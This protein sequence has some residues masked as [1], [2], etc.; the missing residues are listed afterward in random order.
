M[1]APLPSLAPS[2][3]LPSV[4]P[5][6]GSS[7]NS[8]G[9]LGFIAPSSAKTKGS[10]QHSFFKSLGTN[11]R[12]CGTCHQPSQ[13]M[14]ISVDEINN[15]FRRSGAS[16]PLFAPVDGANC[17]N[18]VPP[19]ETAP[20]RY[21]GGRQGR[22]SDSAKARSLLLKDGLIRVFMPLN[23]NADFSIE[24]D[25][26]PYTC[27]TDPNFAKDPSTGVPIFSMYR[28]PLISANLAFKTEFLSFGA[29][30]L[31]N[32]IMWDGR[33]PTLESQAI[34]ATFGHAQRDLATQGNIP[35][36]DV[37]AIVD[38]ETEFFTAQNDD[39]R[40]GGLHRNGGTGGVRNL[41]VNITPSSKVLPSF[42]A[43]GEPFP[44]PLFIPFNEFDGWAT[45]FS[46]HQR[47]VA[48]GQA[49][50]NGTAENDR[51]RFT[52]GE[53]A[54]FNDAFGGPT[55]PQPRQ[56][57]ATCHNGMHG[58]GDML[59]SNQRNI[60]TAGD[61]AGRGGS[62]LRTDLPIFKITCHNGTPNFRTSP[63]FK[64]ND[65]GLALISGKC[66]DVGRITVPSLRGL[67]SRAPYFHDGS[68]NTIADVVKFYNIRFNMG[69]TS[70]EKADLT[71]FLAA[72]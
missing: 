27:N 44:D 40:G 68:A 30:G 35:A 48:R 59:Q 14:S 2:Q 5:A 34:G 57:C 37:K 10:D 21:Y 23:P 58:G 42:P 69:L 64:T 72:L 65:P 47:S 24:V 26:D 32:N 15:R 46:P 7:V 20:S 63:V 53:V 60:G 36:A 25:H 18:L 51:G 56:T 67:S 43:P 41:K 49:L 50:F 12:S 52:M 39:W 38:Y 22:G 55:D 11:G 71:N 62:A 54:G 16:D 19:S 1:G 29:P 70:Q 17:P 13:G 45:S 31:S 9:S 6:E 66:N 8:S 61:F 28:R 4:I 33:E 3:S